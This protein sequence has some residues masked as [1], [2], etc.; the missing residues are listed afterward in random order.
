MWVGG[1]TIKDGEQGAAAKEGG[2]KMDGWDRR[3]KEGRASERARWQE[4]K[5]NIINCRLD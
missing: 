3:R 2:W 1:Q 5:E 4:K